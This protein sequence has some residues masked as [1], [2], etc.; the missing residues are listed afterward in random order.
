MI[1]MDKKKPGFPLGCHSQKTIVK[2]EVFR[3]GFS[4]LFG[5]GNEVS[6]RIG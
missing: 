4:V 3:D 5:F 6:L 2:P 1:G